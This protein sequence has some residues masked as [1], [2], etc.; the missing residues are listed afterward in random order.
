MLFGGM[1]MKRYLKC[2]VWL[3][4]AV[5]LCA[6][7]TGSHGTENHPISGQTTASVPQTPQTEEIVYETD[8]VFKYRALKGAGG[9]AV[10]HW[11]VQPVGEEFWFLHWYAAGGGKPGGFYYDIYDAAGVLQRSLALPEVLWR[12]AIMIAT[13][14]GEYFYTYEAIDAGRRQF[15]CYDAEGNL[16]AQSKN[17]VPLY[18]VSMNKDVQ[19]MQFFG[20]D[21]YYYRNYTV[22]RFPDGDITQDAQIIE[23]PCY[24]DFVSLAPDGRLLVSGTVGSELFDPV[25]HFILDPETEETVKNPLAQNGADIN[26]LFFEAQAIDAV[27]PCGDAIYAFCRDGLY[28][29]RDGAA[30]QIINWSESYLY[31]SSITVQKIVSDQCFLVQY[32][33]P[34]MYNGFEDGMLCLTEERRAQKR[35]VFTLAT[36]GLNLP[37]QKFLDGVVFLFNRDNADYAV[38]YHNYYSLVDDAY[39]MG[40]SNF[41][42]QE[43]ADAAQRQF[44]EDLLSGI[45]YDCYI[46]PEQSSNRDLLADKGLLAD[47]SQYFEEDRIMGCVKTAYETVDGTIALPYFMRLSTLVTSQNVL[48]PQKKLTYDVLLEIAAELDGDETL[49]SQNA[50]E[51]LKTTGQYEFVDPFSGTCS[52][53]SAAGIAWLTFLSEVRA[54]TYSDSTLNIL[55]SFSDANGGQRWY[56]V[57]P[58]LPDEVIRPQRVKFTEMEFGSF[59][60]IAA[61]YW[62]YSKDRISFCGYPSEDET[63]VL[64]SADALFSIATDARCPDGAAAFLDFLFSA[65]I[66]CCDMMSD[67][68]LPV[69][70]EGMTAAFEQWAHFSMREISHIELDWMQD[71]WFQQ[72]PDAFRLLCILRDEKM[73][74]LNIDGNGVFDIVQFTDEDRDLFLRFLDRAVMRTASDAKLQEILDEEL[75]YVESGIRSPAEA[76]AILQSRVSIYLAE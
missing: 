61:A 63:V 53:D 37:Q 64:L 70:R 32:D 23:F 13:Q 8:N 28:A 43:T 31:P 73:D 44:E 2:L 40:Y 74:D 29:A 48:S 71:P 36:V 59:G 21:L 9:E 42:S 4:I 17:Y 39:T 65:D 68:G 75:S 27:F 14:D 58:F 52:F 67:Y 46:F 12:N 22:Y 62:L 66:Q 72:N 51:N 11:S 26:T 1:H 69:S 38:E 34:L 45:V 57:S 55:H 7:D 56:A 5:L 47:L 10:H 25:E 6:C 24:P 50:Y 30:E 54:G 60:A 20:G 19:D 16:L 18:P 35:Q 41:I 33:N 76:A 15:C 3:M 49:F